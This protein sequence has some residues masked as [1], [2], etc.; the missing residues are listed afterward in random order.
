[1]TDI[2]DV[3]G[4]S[5]E[6]T[7]AQPGS[8]LSNLRAR[9]ESIMAEQTL[10]LPVPRWEDPVLVIRYRPV[11]HTQIKKNQ[12]R[13]EKAAKNQ[14]GQ[15]ELEANTDLVVQG[16]VGVFAR[17][18]GQTMVC[19]DVD[20]WEPVDLDSYDGWDKFSPA[21]GETLGAES[22]SARGVVK[23]LFFTDGDIMSHANEIIRF[24]GY[25]E[26]EAD[27]ALEGE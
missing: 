13:I 4:H 7:P 8:P 5:D 16:A 26:A 10:D 22:Q 20:V 12:A 9:R 17:M 21:L 11:E 25:K 14:A 27:E 3:P 23:A 24:S 6:Q 19:T 2:A 18:N 15:V 1:M